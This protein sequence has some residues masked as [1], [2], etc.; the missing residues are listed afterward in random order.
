M[1]SCLYSTH[2]QFLSYDLAPGPVPGAEIYLG[3]QVVCPHTGLNIPTRC[4]GSF[5]NHFCTLHVHPRLALELMLDQ[6]LSNGSVLGARAWHILTCW[7]RRWMV[8]LWGHDVAGS[9]LRI[10]NKV[11]KSVNTGIEEVI[12]LSIT[13]FKC[14]L[15]SMRK[16]MDGRML[17]KQR[18]AQNPP[19]F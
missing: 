16:R 14:I 9:V 2:Q 12:A 19:N 3:T 7:M 8:S 6:C 1:R 17:S 11:P 15:L 4:S 13:W 10:C 18:F 5:Q